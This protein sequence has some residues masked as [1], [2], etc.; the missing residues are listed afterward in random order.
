MLKNRLILNIAGVLIL[1]AGV[2]IALFYFFNKLTGKSFYE[3]QGNRYINGINTEVEIVK[4][5]YGVP[6]ITAKNESDLYFALGYLHAKDRLW[7]MDLTRRVAEGRMS[8]ILGKETVEYDKLFRTIGIG[9]YA[10]KL[11]NEISP[12]SKDILAGYSKGVNE[13]IKENYSRLPLEFDVLN[14]KPEQWK[15]EHSLM[16]IRMMG[17]ELNLSWMT[18]YMFGEIVKKFG[19]ERAKDFFPDYPEDAPYI[20]KSDK[21]PQQQDSKLSSSSPREN[22][23]LKIAELGKNFFAANVDYRNFFGLIGTHIGS[24]S[25]AVNGKKTDKG[26]PIFANDP[27]LVLSAPSKWYEVLMK[28]TADNS[29]VCGF[30]IPGA[31]GVA[32]G[33]NGK[34]C[35]GI[36]NLM[37]DDSDFLILKRDSANPNLYSYR[38]SAVTVDSTQE[39]I[40][41]KDVKDEIPYSVFHTNLGPV[42]SGLNKTGF[43]SD[44][45]FR[46]APNE[47]LTFRWTG[48]ESSDEIKCFYDIYHAAKWEEFKNALTVFGLPASNFTYADADG[49]IGSKAA[50]KVPL[51]N[52]GNSSVDAFTPGYGDVEWTGFI[53]PEEL[54][55]VYNPQENF[56]AA[57]NNKPARDYRYY[58]SNLYEPP[59]RAIRIEDVLKSKNNITSQE[60]RLLQNDVTS[61]QA[62]E[63]FYYLTEAFRDSSKLT[64]GERNVI[65][66]IRKWNFDFNKLSGLASL[67]AEFEIC[68]YINLYR[69]KLGNALFNEYIYLNN[70]PVRNTAKILKQ[71]DSWLLGVPKDSLKNDLRNE[72]VRKSFRE[73]I[74]LLR[75]KFNETDVDKCEWGAMHKVMIKHPLGSVR[76]LDK[77]LNIGPFETGGAGTTV[78]N[79]EYSFRSAIEQQEFEC[80]VGPSLR[81]IFD[82]NEPGFYLSILPSGQSGQPQHTNYSDQTRAWLNAEYKK[83]FINISDFRSNSDSK[84]LMLLPR[85]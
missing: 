45:A 50:G 25:W 53:K 71:N 60:F 46:T 48:F 13:F 2:S 68:L 85:Q 72:L 38:N 76:T 61:P 31:P 84:T 35:W 73:A 49:N 19:I 16:V 43:S 11:Y 51:R 75:Q 44:N 79:A 82:F 65:Q 27:H 39:Y 55:E 66:K 70:V 83:V 67:F 14:Y 5:N 23:Y 17:W 34:I 69:D 40:K 33:S 37:N 20:I 24:N 81:F 18:E 29:F 77:I 32:I 6:Y 9:K 3:E 22:N 10:Y 12:K 7:Q 56:V 47:I 15:P 41:V 42:I 63:F 59:Y 30:S 74:E 58:I 57:A 36:T 4:D 1:L 26:K 52:T 62:K 78:S 64:A 28:N 8:E 54:P 80:R 21:K